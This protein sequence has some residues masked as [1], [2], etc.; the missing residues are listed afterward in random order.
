MPV[1][2]KKIEKPEDIYD[3]DFHESKD[4]NNWQYV[5][6]VPGGWIYQF[7][8]PPDEGTDY[9]VFVPFNEEFNY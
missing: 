8:S 4:I 1:T 2:D 5:L 7:N 3:M 9:G 6:R